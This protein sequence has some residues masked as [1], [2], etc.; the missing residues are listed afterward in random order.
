MPEPLEKDELYVLLQNNAVADLVWPEIERLRSALADRE[1]I[2]RGQHQQMVDQQNDFEAWR[3]ESER[4]ARV[5]AA[6]F[7]DEQGARARY[8]L[9][10]RRIMELP[11]EWAVESGVPTPFVQAQ[12]LADEALNWTGPAE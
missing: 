7:L 4:E 1:V 2:V 8:E 10:L 3:L 5:D 12:Q 9:A 6:R 11:R